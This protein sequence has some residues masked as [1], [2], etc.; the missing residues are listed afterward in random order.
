MDDHT[1]S[2]TSKLSARIHTLPRT[3][4]LCQ[5]GTKR[6]L[7]KISHKNRQNFPPKIS[8]TGLNRFFSWLGFLQCRLHQQLKQVNRRQV[9]K[10]T[11]PRNLSSSNAKQKPVFAIQF[12]RQHPLGKRSRAS[13]RRISTLRCIVVPSFSVAKAK[14]LAIMRYLQFLPMHASERMLNY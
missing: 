5:G 7:P 9:F 6:N 3:P 2:A 10:Y 11:S 13:G 1:H 8:I 4:P 14:T 12:Q